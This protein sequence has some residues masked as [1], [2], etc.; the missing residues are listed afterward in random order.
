MRVEGRRVHHLA[1]AVGGDGVERGRE[2]TREGVRERKRVC[3][4]VREGESKSE[5]G[6][7]GQKESV[8]EGNI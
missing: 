2:R 8:C 3:V 5:R 7:E 6:G 4:H 1:D